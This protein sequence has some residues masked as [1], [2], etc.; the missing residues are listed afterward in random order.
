MWEYLCCFYFY[1]STTTTN[2]KQI[3]S[4]CFFLFYLSCFF[5]KQLLTIRFS[6]LGSCLSPATEGILL[7]IALRAP[8]RYST[9]WSATCNSS[10][11]STSLLSALQ[12][13]RT[14][15][16]RSP[17][18]S[19]KP[20]S[21]IAALLSGRRRNTINKPYQSRDTEPIFIIVLPEKRLVGELFHSEKLFLHDLRLQTKH[22]LFYCRGEVRSSGGPLV[23]S[24]KYCEKLW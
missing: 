7:L 23:I 3:F 18:S 21:Q 20:L 9:L 17:W 22:Y 11:L 8:L 14:N 1:W 19:I 13:T 12:N 4:Q 6:M 2:K 5:G 10:W 16:H 15:H 24:T